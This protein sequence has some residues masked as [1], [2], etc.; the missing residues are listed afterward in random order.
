MNVNVRPQFYLDIEEEVY[1]LLGNAGKDVALKWHDAVWQT[2]GMLKAH[3]YLG[4]ERKDLKESGVR[5]WRVRA[6]PR[7]II[8]YKAEEQSLVLCRVRSGLMDLSKLKMR[9]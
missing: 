4:R 5:S 1:W 6:F 3:P 8:F 9:S 7:W 2:V